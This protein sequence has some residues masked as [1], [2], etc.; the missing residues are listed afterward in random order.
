MRHGISRFFNQTAACPDQAMNHL[1]II[2]QSWLTIKLAVRVLILLILV[3]FGFPPANRQC[4][5][6]V[7]VRRSFRSESCTIQPNP[8]SSDLQSTFKIYLFMMRFHSMSHDL[9]F[10]SAFSQLM[11]QRFEFTLSKL[12][13][14]Y[15]MRST[16][17]SSIS[18]TLRG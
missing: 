12:Q 4:F 8:S 5:L 9:F 18:H 1:E 7:T 6:R 10:N 3:S 2:L 16:T 14:K 15:K 13:L 17:L 11:H